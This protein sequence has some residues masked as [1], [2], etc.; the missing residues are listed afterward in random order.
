VVTQDCQAC[1]AKKT[2]YSQPFLGN[3][4]AGNVLLSGAI[5]FAG[6]LPGKVLRVFK[7]FRLA[8]ICT[9]TFMAHQRQYLQPTIARVY[10]QNQRALLAQLKSRTSP[11]V[12][13][14]DGR[15]DSPGHSAK[16]GSYGLV[17]EET[18]M[19]VDIKLV[20]VKEQNIVQKHKINTKLI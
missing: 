20:Q 12:L 6:A 18:G 7:H 9:S 1:P 17:D 19:I 5:L 10:L 3:V 8:S 2:W 13:G 16:Y 11:I 4:P 14:G 15:A